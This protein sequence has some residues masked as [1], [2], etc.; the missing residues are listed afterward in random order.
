MSAKEK[1]IEMLNNYRPLCGGYNG[2]KLNK[3]F[4]KQSAMLAINE[5]IDTMGVLDSLTDD[6]KYNLLTDTIDCKY[7]YWNEVK[8]EL[9][10]L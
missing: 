4:A 7:H 8:K 3:V 5:I 6:V 1:A 2:G 10:L 9:E